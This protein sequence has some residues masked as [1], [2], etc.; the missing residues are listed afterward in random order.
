MRNLLNDQP[1]PFS[2][3]LLA[4]RVSQKAAIPAMCQ[5]VGKAPQVMM[6]AWLADHSAAQIRPQLLEILQQDAIQY[7]DTAI[8]CHPLHP[9]GWLV[10]FHLLMHGASDPALSDIRHTY[11]LAPR[12]NLGHENRCTGI[13][14]LH[15]LVSGQHGP[16]SF[17]T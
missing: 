15:A 14:C 11:K 1:Y 9:L 2:D 16:R 17:D 5:P 7:A 13:A 6:A 10:R 8:R 4:G 3:I 12:E